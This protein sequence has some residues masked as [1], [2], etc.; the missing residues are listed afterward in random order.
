MNRTPT[1]RTRVSRIGLDIGASGVRAAQLSVTPTHADLVA[2]GQCKASDP[3]AQT[4]DRAAANAKLIRRCLAQSTFRGRAVVAGLNSPQIEFHA[5][6][7][8]MLSGRA[9]RGGDAE[10]AHH[11]ITRLR[12]EGA[13]TV[14]TAHWP[15]P[16]TKAS[17]PTAIGVAAP[18][19]DVWETLECCRAAALSCQCVDATAAA[20]SRFGCWLNEWAPD[21]IWGLL[22]LGLRETRL[23]LCVDEVP[24]LVRSVGLGGDAWTQR[25][26]ESLGISPEAA[27]VQK[28]RFGVWLNAPAKPVEAA[29]GPASEVSSILSGVLRSDLNALAGEIKRSY[30]YALSCYPDRGAGDLVLV[31]AA[32]VMP[33]LSDYLE[34]LLGITVRVASDYLADEGC[35]LNWSSGKNRTLE[36]FAT[37]VG[38]ALGEA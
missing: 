1:K 35:R 36:A 27:E 37:A 19:D 16:E 25:I 11:E 15:L 8:P 5:L 21:S 17:A 30:Q 31:G 26:A 20:L 38:L 13:G 2:L 34:D 24:V 29:D 6:E 28:C 4:H 14:E 10:L 33:R 22:D 12:A 9:M 18:V 3:T 32:A 7:L 23:I